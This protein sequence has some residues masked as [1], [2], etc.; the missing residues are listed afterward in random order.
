MIL[1]KILKRNQSWTQSHIDRQIPEKI[2]QSSIS[3]DMTPLPQN[4]LEHGQKVQSS[5]VDS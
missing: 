1:I 3:N 4:N 5:F 2:S